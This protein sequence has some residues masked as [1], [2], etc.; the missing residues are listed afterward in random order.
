MRNLDEIKTKKKKAQHHR[1]GMS[2]SLDDVD[3]NLRFPSNAFPEGIKRNP[4]RFD[5]TRF[6]KIGMQLKSTGFDL[7]HC[8]RPN[9]VESD[10]HYCIMFL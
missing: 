5:K 1:P 8:S 10:Q 9:D 7:P 6:R 2:V 4:V 3:P